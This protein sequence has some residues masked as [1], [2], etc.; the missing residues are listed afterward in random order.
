MYDQAAGAYQQVGIA[1]AEP[2]RLVI[3]CYTGAIDNLR[4]S[5][6]HYSQGELERKA[7]TLSKA[8]DFIGE[9]NRSLDFEK[10][11]EIAVKLHALYNYML[12]R[13]M[14]GDLRKN[15]A[16]FTEVINM[17]QELRSAWEEILSRSQRPTAAMPISGNSQSAF[18]RKYMEA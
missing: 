15:T 11:G 3:M 18:G 6:D 7:E 13:I 8:I 16:A 5:I 4:N 10:G 1:T 2:G 14:E 9:L 17:L 12:R